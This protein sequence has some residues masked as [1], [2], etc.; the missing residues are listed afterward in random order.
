[1]VLGIRFLNR[2]LIAPAEA[3][4]ARAV[5]AA[6]PAAG[7]PFKGVRSFHVP[8]QNRY[9]AVEFS[10]T[11]FG[12]VGFIAWASSSGKGGDSSFNGRR[13]GWR[14]VAR[15]GV[16]RPQRPFLPCCLLSR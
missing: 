9:R 3:V 11:R 8:S 2:K 4:D 12:P 13:A 5:V 16:R 14:E 10:P 1:M 6:K 15:Q 7:R